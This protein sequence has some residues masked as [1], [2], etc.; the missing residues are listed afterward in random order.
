M[1]WVNT[2]VTSIKLLHNG[3]QIHQIRHHHCCPQT[4]PKPVLVVQQNIREVHPCSRGHHHAASSLAVMCGV[5]VAYLMWNSRCDLCVG[6][7]FHIM[8]TTILGSATYIW[9]FT[10]LIYCWF[11]CHAL[12]QWT[13]ELMVNHFCI[14]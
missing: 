13:A 2:V 7:S 5:L 8:T 11:V 10:L 1:H 14:C 3:Y 9:D 12:W 6:V 4:I